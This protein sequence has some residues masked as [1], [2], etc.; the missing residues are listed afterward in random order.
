M[1]AERGL[2]K[3]VAG[4]LK[5][6]DW[7]FDSVP[8]SE[9]V[10]CC[11]WEYARESAFVRDLRKRSWQHWKPLFL[12]GGW[13]NAP[14]NKG[15]KADLLK[16]E[17]I[18]YPAEVILRGIACPPDGVLP[19][20]TSLKPG[21][22]YPVTGSFPKPWQKLTNE[23]RA[24]RS[25][26]GSDVERIPLVPFER[27]HSLDAKGI[28]EW[29]EARQREIAA[30]NERVRR[31][32]PKAGDEALCREGKLQFQIIQPSL[33]W[34]SGKEETVVGIQWAAF[35]DDE[36]ASYFRKWVKVNRPA[37][38]PA[39]NAQGRKRISD[40]VKLERLAI[41]RL[42]HQFTVAELRT[43]RPDA[44]KLY[45]KPNR[46]WR[47]DVEKSH[48]HFHDLFPFLPKDEFPRSW[49]PKAWLGQMK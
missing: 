23:E 37:S 17:S 9:L 4:P 29:V 47:K 5:R 43:I 31:E 3:D 8:V 33:C 13:W 27:G 21:E 12:K 20:A 19:D 40:R 41:M 36:I 28:V 7:D 24:Y 6:E 30:A 15:I 34:P 32:N 1:K 44:W 48:A 25:Q 11:Y 26:I 18:G 2:N 42:L 14:E 45:N 39:P 38:I 35:T 46:R 16:V 10:A 22:V 49:P